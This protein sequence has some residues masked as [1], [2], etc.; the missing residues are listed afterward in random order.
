MGFGSP[1]AVNGGS[2]ARVGRWERS[3]RD[4]RM[5]RRRRRADEPEWEPMP[6]AELMAT[7]SATAATEWVDLL[8][9]TPLAPVA[10]DRLRGALRFAFES[11]D[12]GRLLSLV[13]DQAP[14]APTTWDV[15]GFDSG[16]FVDDLLESLFEITTDQSGTNPIKPSKTFLKRLLVAPPTDPRD[17]TLRQACLAELAHSPDLRASATRTYLHLRRLRALLDEQP[18][19]P[20]DTIRRKIDV[21]TA[22]KSF[23]DE[24]DRGLAHASSELSRLHQFAAAV[25][26]SESYA[27]LEQVLEFDAHLATLDVQVIVGSDGRLRDFKLIRSRENTANPYVQSPWRRAWSRLRAWMRGYR[28]GEQEILLKVLDGV[29]S[30]LEEYLLPVFRL[31]G[32]LELYLA[33]LSFKERCEA[34]GLTVC[35]PTLLPT[36]A[37]TEPASAFELEGLF[38][39][40]LFLQDTVPVPCN[41]RAAGHDAITIVTGPNSGG[42]TR[43]LQ[44]TALAQLLAHNG[45]YV[46][47][48]R[49]TLTRAPTMFVSLVEAGVANQKEGRLGT[50]LLR[51]RKLFER[52]QPGALV[53]F[54]EL[55][56]GTNPSEG[57]AI[58]EMVI[59]LLPKLRPQVLLTTHFLDAARRMQSERPAERLSFL[60]VELDGEQPT[61]QFV[62]GVAETSLAHQVASRLGVTRDQLLA[63]VDSQGQAKTSPHTPP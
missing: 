17:V 60:Q 22:V 62:E 58:L 61:Y 21:L 3:I 37:S 9:H 23:F 54:D 47:A 35:L 52:L 45:L 30:E 16:L 36:P 29:F 32:H 63:L 50:E 26:N 13:V 15:E 14:L 31:I 10:V 38:N 34:K 6:I 19:T 41:F 56:S 28:Y 33:T 39:P 24:A 2:S 12:A 11:G 25:R 44:A 27:R 46:P 5:L 43:L 42:K 57:I 51:V 40:L 4:R 53:I 55:C 7:G 18:M 59:S 8:H 1:A 20:G 48:A 49:A